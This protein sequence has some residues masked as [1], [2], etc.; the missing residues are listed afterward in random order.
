MSLTVVEIRLTIPD[1]AARTA[2][3]TLTRL[4]VPV[5]G[6]ERAELLFVEHE[7]PP[8]AIAAAVR[9]DEIRFNENT[10]DLRVRFQSSPAVGELWVHDE[11]PTIRTIVGLGRAQAAVLWRLTDR[12]GEPANHALLNEAA[13]RLLCHPVIQRATL[14]S[15]PLGGEHPTLR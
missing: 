6:L 15:L 13:K 8:A 11:P 10:Q 4:G 1:N 12:E 9:A 2:F 14:G 5:G 7:L 3:A